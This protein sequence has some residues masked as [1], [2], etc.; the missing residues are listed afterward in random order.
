MGISKKIEVF[1]GSVI[2]FVKCRN[3][4]TKVSQQ[5]DG[6]LRVSE[7]VATTWRDLGS[8]LSFVKSTEI[9]TENSKILTVRWNITKLSGRLVE[10]WDPSYPLLKFSTGSSQEHQTSPNLPQ[11]GQSLKGVAHGP[12]SAKII[13]YFLFNFNLFVL[14]GRMSLKGGIRYSIHRNC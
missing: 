1:S 4:Y 9:C 8:I 6:V 3:V 14:K 13:N 10:I 5:N 11:I 2:S 7:A 12:E